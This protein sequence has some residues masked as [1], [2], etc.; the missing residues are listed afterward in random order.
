MTHTAKEIQLEVFGPATREYHLA[1]LK[2]SG[3][4]S[5]NTRDWCKLHNKIINSRTWVNGDAYDRA[6]MITIMVLASQSDNQIPWDEQYIAQAGSL[7]L[8]PDE[9]TLDISHLI[10]SG[11]IEIR[12]GAPG[13]KA[14]DKA[15]PAEEKKKTK[16]GKLRAEEYR[17]KN[18]AKL[19]RFEEFYD[20]YPNHAGKS[21]AERQWVEHN[22][23]EIA[24]QIINHLRDRIAAGWESKN[25]ESGETHF[26]KMAKTYL[27]NAMWEDKIDGAVRKKAFDEVGTLEPGRVM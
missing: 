6:L 25:I 17:K 19:R 8:R 26:I 4:Q 12:D 3:Y 22:C 27:F 21:D 16:G 14:A 10:Q 9:N 5:P 13:T 23:D 1:I 15:A 20:M 24:D 2:W 18:A 7:E 11:F